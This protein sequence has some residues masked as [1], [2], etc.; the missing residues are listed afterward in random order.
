MK[1]QHMS[2]SGK[3][4]LVITL[5]LVVV[6]VTACSGVTPATDRS[7]P[8]VSTPVLIK[9][10][11]GVVQSNEAGSV[12]IKVQWVIAEGNSLIFQVDMDTHSVN[13]DQYDLK[14][15]AV[16]RDDMGNEYHPVSWESAAGGH[17]RQGK[18]TFLLPDSLRQRTAKYLEM[19]IRDVAGIEIRVLKW[20]L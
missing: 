20:E 12:V 9:P 10:T 11:N 7:S 14:Q 19:V 16:L 4:L 18:L 8:T 13:L 6:I 15:L 1:E 2:Q 3:S 5:L 17:H